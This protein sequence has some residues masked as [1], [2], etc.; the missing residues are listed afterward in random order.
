MT[1]GR[2]APSPTGELHLGNLRTALGAWHRARDLDGQFLLRWEDLDGANAAPEWETAQARDLSLVGIDW[3]GTPVRQSE[4]FDRY[5]AALARLS[6]AGLTYECYCSR[7]EI[8]EAAAAPHGH[9]GYDYPG[10]CRDLTGP[11]RAAR[12][13]AGRPGALRLRANAEVIRFVDEVHGPQAIRVDDFVL[14]RNDGTPAYHVAVVVDDADAE[15][16]QVVRAD[17]LLPS[18][19]RQLLLYRL[20]DLPKP[21]TY[22]HLPLVVGPNGSRLAKRDGA[23][24]LGDRPEPPDEIAQWLLESLGPPE[25]PST[26]PLVIDPDQP[27]F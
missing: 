9:Y 2:F 1:V 17:D 5:H 10:T 7:R 3:D 22:A 4:R 26:E 25:R 8:R 27:L 6:D 20:L 13:A 21:D 16:T 14:R 11:E 15:V 19:A 12:Q 18:A 23:V 24:T